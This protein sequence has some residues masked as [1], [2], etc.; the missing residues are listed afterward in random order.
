MA[1]VERDTVEV[2]STYIPDTT[3]HRLNGEYVVRM[4]VSPRSWIWMSADEADEIADRIKACAIHARSY[5]SSDDFDDEQTVAPVAP[6]PG[7]REA[8]AKATRRALCAW[9]EAN[10]PDGLNGVQD[11]GMDGYREA[12]DAVLSV[13]AE[14]GVR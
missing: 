12:A 5:V 2:E 14:R 3:L 11:A 9:A 1:T 8:I 10:F 6:D 13:L 7:L 4:A